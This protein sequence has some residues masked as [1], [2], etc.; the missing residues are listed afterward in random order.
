MR[1]GF[2][3]FG[4]LGKQIYNLLEEDVNNYDFVFFDDSINLPKEN[5][6]GQFRPFEDYLSEDYKGCFFIV[7]LG[8]KHLKKKLLIINEIMENGRSLFSFVHPTT[9]CHSSADIK[10]GVVVY[11]GCIIDQN[12]TIKEGSIINNGVIISHDSVV[13]KCCF[14]APGVKLSG[15]VLLR[16]CC[17]IGTGT[18]ISNRVSLARSSII[19]AGSV[20]LKSILI[21]EGTYIGNPLRKVSYLN[22]I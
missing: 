11:P 15:N 2:I 1:V 20:V 7:A 6:T 17:F 19:G 3:G 8:Y 12:V 18:T 14:L 10:D 4:A 9:Y 16:E 5:Y 21:E 22:L 13:E